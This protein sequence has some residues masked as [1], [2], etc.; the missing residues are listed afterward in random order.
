MTAIPPVILS[1]SSELRES[2]RNR[3]G[4]LK[5]TDKDQ[6]ILAR[7]KLTT[8]DEIVNWIRFAEVILP[9]IG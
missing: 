9:I 2:V 8:T 3:D 7:L 4:V 1:L 5:M 6:I